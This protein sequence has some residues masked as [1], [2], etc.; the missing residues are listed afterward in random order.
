[1]CQ[2]QQLQRWNSLPS[3]TL[4]CLSVVTTIVREGEKRIKSLL[5]TLACGTFLGALGVFAT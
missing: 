2:E 5:R 3:S 1:M 4:E